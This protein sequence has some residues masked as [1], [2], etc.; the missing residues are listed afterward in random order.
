MNVLKRLRVGLLALGALGLVLVWGSAHTWAASPALPPRPTPTLRPT[1]TP[2]PTPTPT[3]TAPSAP[4]VEDGAEGGA[5]VLLARGTRTVEAWQA[6]WTVVTW[7]DDAGAWQPVAGWQGPFDQVYGGHARKTWNVAEAVL[8]RG[9]FRWEVYARE[10]VARGEAPLAISAPFDLPEAIGESVTVEVALDAAEA[11]EAA[12]PVLL[13][14]SGTTAGW[15]LWGKLGMLAL[16]VVLVGLALH[17]RAAP[18]G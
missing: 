6:M 8:G 15:G 17:G 4:P 2:T 9:P 14:A 11:A 10:A 5:I 1:R 12:A 13:P 3:P 16:L 7:Q 18:S